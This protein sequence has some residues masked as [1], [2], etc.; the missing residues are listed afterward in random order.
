MTEYEH[1]SDGFT[2]VEDRVRWLHGAGR[3]RE[4]IG[5]VD[6]LFVDENDQPEYFG[7][8]MGFLGAR[9]TLIPADIT[10]DRQATGLIEVSQ[11]KRRSRTARASMTT[12]R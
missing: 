8:K 2:A 6:D 10:S 9:S 12:K 7:V 4:K 3:R 1:R 5:K 11:P